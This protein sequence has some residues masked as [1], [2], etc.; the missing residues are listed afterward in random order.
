MFKLFFF[1][2]IVMDLLSCDIHSLIA[3][4]KI[5]QMSENFHRNYVIDMCNKAKA[6]GQDVAQSLPVQ[7]I[8]LFLCFNRL[9]SKW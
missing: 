6:S 5:L 9:Y 3:I 8:C 7:Y 4:K 2:F 1:R